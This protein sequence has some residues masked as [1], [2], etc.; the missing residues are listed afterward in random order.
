MNPHTKKHGVTLAQAQWYKEMKALADF[1]PLPTGINK[2]Q[3]YKGASG[4]IE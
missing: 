2:I 3:N 1:L 4:I